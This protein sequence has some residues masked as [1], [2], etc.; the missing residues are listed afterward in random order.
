[1]NAQLQTQ[2][3][4]GISSTGTFAFG[5]LL[6]RKCS[7]GNHTLAGS[8]CEM[9]RDKDEPR[10]QRA[11]VNSEGVQRVPP[12]VHEVLRSAG[13]PLDPETRAFFEPRFGHDFSNV[14]LHTDAQA[15]ASAHAINAL[16]YTYSRHVVFGP[17]QF[18]PLSIRGRHLIAHE[19]A[20][21][22]QQRRSEAAIQ[23]MLA[24]PS[25]L[26]AGDP[27]PSGWKPYQGDSSVFH[28]GFRGMLED[29]AP[30][31]D[32]LQNEC[33]YDHSGGLVD[34]THPY[35][36]CRGTPNRY[37]SRQL[38]GIPHATIDPGGIVRAGGPA[39]IT[40]RVHDLNRAISSAIR[41]VSTTAH[42]AGSILNALGDA[43]ALGVL[44]AAATVDPG[45]WRFQGLPA[46]TVRHLNVMGAILGSTTLSQNADA[47]LRNLTRR[48]DSFPIA[49][50]LDEIAQDINR[51]LQSRGV[52]AQQVTSSELGALSLIQLVEWLRI[53]GILQYARPPED[54]AREQ[55]AAQR[56]ATP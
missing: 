44:T 29:R 17:G 39:F 38:L 53:Q 1:M 26:A 28:C 2:A 42:V 32:D 54:I 27:V 50:L 10:L 15:G 18:E 16:A 3:R 48:L 23:R 43:I 45:N 37:D 35:A 56:A 46:R 7:C 20:H 22:V 11:A 19:L 14:R 30:T 13:Q 47:L 4:N 21:V 8:E 51:A 31:A 36:G 49:G 34:E 40:S 12:I 41:V 6:Q 55:L 52:G 24:C 25:R 5:R 9:C 33:F